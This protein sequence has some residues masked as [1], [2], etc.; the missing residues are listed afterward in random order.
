M[1]RCREPENPSTSA[2]SVYRPTAPGAGQR[3]ISP[4]ALS[5]DSKILCTRLIHSARTL[6]APPIPER[7]YRQLGHGVGVPGEHRRLHPHAPDPRAH[8]ERDKDRVYVHWRAVSSGRHAT[9]GRAT[10][11]VRRQSTAP[12]QQTS[13]ARARS[14]AA[15]VA[16]GEAHVLI[17]RYALQAECPRCKYSPRGRSPQHR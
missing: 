11:G 6:V 10:H 12:C 7:L 17:V 5:H 3:D 9:R 14:V 13:S 16:S 8:I 1:V 4:S 2:P 15:S